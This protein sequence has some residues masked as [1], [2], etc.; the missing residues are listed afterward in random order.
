MTEFWPVDCCP[1]KSLHPTNDHPAPNAVPIQSGRWLRKRLIAA[2]LAAVVLAVF[3]LMPSR[4]VARKL[5][6]PNVRMVAELNG[7]SRALNQEFG[8]L[9]PVPLINCGPC[10][11]F[12]KIFYDEWQAR[13]GQRLKFVFILTYDRKDCV[14][15][16]LRLPDGS[17]FDGGLGVMSRELLDAEFFHPPIV[18]QAEYDLME[19]NERSYG[20]L[21]QYPDCPKFDAAKARKLVRSVLSCMPAPTPARFTDS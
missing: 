10:G 4:G 12:A 16:L 17:Y 18:E 9:G 13:Y 5:P 15:V 8:T 6:A 11:R 1:L 3:S 19:L 20:L 2:V 14:H 21:R 7:L